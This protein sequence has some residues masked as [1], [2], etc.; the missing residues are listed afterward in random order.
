MT[1]L[2]AAAV[3]AGLF[4]A[5]AHPPWPRWPMV[6]LD[7][8]VFEWFQAMRT[9]GGEALFAALTVLGAPRTIGFLT[10]AAAIAFL[11]TGRTW[12]AWILVA[13]V[14]CTAL[15]NDE[16]KIFFARARPLDASSFRS[17]PSG[18]AAMST[19][20]Y[21]GLAL[22]ATRRPRFRKWAFAAIPGAAVLAAF[23]GVSRLYLGVHWL[24]DVLAG[25]VLGLIP[26][27][28]GAAFAGGRKL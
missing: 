12:E 17:F 1:G 3:L 8:R 25:H 11:A 6:G 9:P 15:L 23:I 20:F 13:C 14:G 26:L 16:L 27:S 22:L 28:I 24:S 7:A 2:A 19:S 18:H 21:V 10:A 5:L 4:L